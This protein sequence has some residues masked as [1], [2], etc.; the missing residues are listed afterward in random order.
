MVLYILYIY[1]TNGSV[2][3]LSISNYINI[4]ISHTFVDMKAESRKKK[5]KEKKKKK[6]DPQLKQ[7]SPDLIESETTRLFGCFFLLCGKKEEEENTFGDC[8]R[9]EKLFHST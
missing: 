1:I 2:E 9:T 3:C 4:N 6:T 5:K 8:E 7:T